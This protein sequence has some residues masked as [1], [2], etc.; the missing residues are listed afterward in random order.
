MRDA[1]FLVYLPD[2]FGL[3]RSEFFVRDG[4]GQGGYVNPH[5]LKNV[6]STVVTIEAQQLIADL[7][8]WDAQPPPNLIDIAEALKL[9]RGKARDAGG[10]KASDPWRLLKQVARDQDA[11]TT[12]SAFRQMFE[13]QGEWPDNQADRA[14]IFEILGMTLQAAWAK[15]YDGLEVSEEL[16]RF[17]EVETPVAQVFYNRQRLGIRVD[18]DKIGESIAVADREKYTAYNKIAE[19]VQISPSG[20]HFRNVGHVLQRTDAAHLYPFIDAPNF[21][22]YIRLAA[23]NSSFAQQL[24]TLV[25]SSRDLRALARL[26]GDPAGLAHPEFRIMG[27]VTGRILVANPS[28]QQLRRQHRNVIAAA[29]GMRL[30]YLDFAQFEPGILASLSGDRDFIERYNTGDIYTELALA[31]FDDVGR[32]DVAKR[33]FLAFSYGMTPDRIIALVGGEDSTDRLAAFE[34]FI[35]CFPGL[36][37]F[38]GACEASLHKDGYIGTL[39]G[40]R[41]YRT[42]GGK[43]THE[44]RRW[45]VSQAVQGTASLIFKEAILGVAQKLGP[46][47]ILLPM[48]DAIL[49][50]LPQSSYDGDVQSIQQIML[51]SLTSRCPEISGR[52][53][54]TDHF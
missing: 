36:L 34:R 50:Q 42:G 54:T 35:S 13:A 4:Q 17:D 31:L 38:R 45:A 21:E 11:A 48:H 33:M 32:R 1:S 9:W 27:T 15:V 30:A 52:V 14:T 20:L 16:E 3:G 7:R 49:V 51:S 25:R 12:I 2:L 23:A 41:R 47:T 37:E 18:L 22:E 24:V 46:E 5:S 28:L 29:E 10:A 43:L 44:E 19:S 8:N 26:R 53:V 6:D 39:M 40:N